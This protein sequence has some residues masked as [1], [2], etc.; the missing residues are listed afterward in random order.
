MQKFDKDFKS[1]NFEDNFTGLYLN[2]QKYYENK[3]NDN[4]NYTV[5]NLIEEVTH[6]IYSNF[7]FSFKFGISSN[8]LLAKFNA[9]CY[10]NTNTKIPQDI[11][12]F[13]ENEQNLLNK[14]SVEELNLGEFYKELFKAIDIKTIEDVLNN[15]Y[16]LFYILCETSFEKIFFQILGYNNDFLINEEVTFDEPT[17]NLGE[18]NNYLKKLSQTVYE[19]I[20]NQLFIGNKL[21]IEV[22]DC[23]YESYF[24][25]LIIEG[26][27]ASPEEI[28][29]NIQ[30]KLKEIIENKMILL[31]SLGITY[32]GNY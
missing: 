26:Y 20:E 2:I 10:E 13:T 18:I 19:K 30:S 24:E 15:A 7:S 1:L 21:T 11:I 22:K 12:G 4:D 9:I 29:Y 5:H 23:E 32:E 8:K 17:D 31:L 6:M 27:F 16:K 14:I 25:N 3:Q 28:S